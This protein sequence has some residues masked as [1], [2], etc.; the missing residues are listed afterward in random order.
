MARAVTLLTILLL[1]GAGASAAPGLSA[2]AGSSDWTAAADEILAGDAYQT[3]IP[4]DELDRPAG[5]WVFGPVASVILISLLVVVVALV[6]TWIVHEWLQS[7]RAGSRKDEAGE[8][9]QEAEL[10]GSGRTDLARPRRLAEAGRFAEAMHEL[11]L[12]AIGYLSRQAVAG[13]DRSLTSRELIRRLDLA[14]TRRQAFRELV[15]AVETCHFGTRQPESRDYEACVDR[16][17]ALVG[18]EPS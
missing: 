15:L 12:I 9:R 4:E 6:L 13:R 2:Q 5:S 18:E 7:R 17:R 11:L 14:E 1:L 10:R 3:E 16:F 8:D